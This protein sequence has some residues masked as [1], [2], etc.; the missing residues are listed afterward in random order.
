M[1]KEEN[2]IAT[3]PLRMKEKTRIMA[4]RDPA[5]WPF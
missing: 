5:S 4:K 2:K 1:T 3:R